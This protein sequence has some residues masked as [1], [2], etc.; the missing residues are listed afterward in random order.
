MEVRLRR[1]A[2][3]RARPARETDATPRSCTRARATRPRPLHRQPLARPAPQH[4]TLPQAPRTATHTLHALTQPTTCPRAE[5][6]GLPERFERLTHV[7][8]VAQAENHRARAATAQQRQ[9]PGGLA[10]SE[11]A[12]HDMLQHSLIQDSAQ[13]V[14]PTPEQIRT[15]RARQRQQRRAQARQKRARER[16]PHTDHTRLCKSQVKPPQSWTSLV[17]IN[18]NTKVVTVS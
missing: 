1:A 15:P 13:P 7:H 11:Q 2:T 10:L 12:A 5:T 8:P 14:R 9:Q 4:W 17:N 16:G 6:P 18:V 3:P